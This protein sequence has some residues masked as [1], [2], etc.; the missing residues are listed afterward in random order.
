MRSVGEPNGA[1]GTVPVNV[2]K[3]SRK[4]GGG[5]KTGSDASASNLRRRLPKRLPNGKP[6]RG[7]ARG[8]GRGRTKMM[9]V[10]IG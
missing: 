10:T 5:R 9:T 8:K 3:S 2:R 1:N 6:L 4:N 7:N